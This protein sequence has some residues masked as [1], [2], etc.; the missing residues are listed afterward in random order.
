MD[1]LRH[2]ARL[3]TPKEFVH[4]ARVD[5]AVCR[6]ICDGITP[7]DPWCLRW[8]AYLHSK[9]WCDGHTWTARSVVPRVLSRTCRACSRYTERRVF[10]VPLCERCTRD[11][12]KKW[13]MVSVASLGN[14]WKPGLAPTHSGRRGLLVFKPHLCKKQ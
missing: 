2:I 9:W 11:T 6:V 12:S 4:L 13:H 1:V 7:M 5:R 14:K 3:L 10:G 8:E